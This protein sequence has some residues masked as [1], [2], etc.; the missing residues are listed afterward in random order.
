MNRVRI[1]TGPKHAATISVPGNLSVSREAFDAALVA[2]A[3]EAGV[4]VRTG[5]R[6]SVGPTTGEAR[7]VHIQSP[8]P[9]QILSRV[10]IDG[11]GLAGADGP[12]S[13][14]SRIGVGIVL[15][16]E[17][18]PAYYGTGT[19]HLAVSP[20]GY[21]GLVRVEQNRLDVAAALDPAYIRSRGGPQLAVERNTRDSPAGRACSYRKVTPGKGY[22]PSDCRRPTVR[23]GPRLFV[24]GDAAGYVE[25]LTGE[26][27]AWAIASAIA[28]AP[29][30]TRAVDGWHDDMIGEW[31]RT[32]SRLIGRR[33]LTCR[34]A[35][36]ALLHARRP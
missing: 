16:A 15:A 35:P 10:A 7:I 23:A 36:R 12:V 21:V 8:K 27:M 30:V 19:I 25:P 34:V 26:G 18:A 29:I 31:T 24:I 2:A 33:Q 17:K 11:T 14:G 20:A 4:T 32:H 6:A 5:V 13:A 3:A 28:V 22:A 1:A 9:E